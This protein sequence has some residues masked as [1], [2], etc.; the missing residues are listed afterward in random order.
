M[1]RIAGWLLVSLACVAFALPAI[2]EEPTGTLHISARPRCTVEIDGKDY[3]TTDDTRKGIPLPAGSYTVR[4]VCA[5]EEKCAQFDKRSGRKTLA[6]EA[7]KETRYL[8]D[9][10][11]L[12]QRGGRSTSSSSPEPAAAPPP[13][14][15]GPAGALTLT[16]K[17][18]ARVEIGSTAYGSIGA[19]PWTVWLPPGEHVVRFVCEG[20]ACD[21]MTRRS[22][23]KTIAITEDA[24]TRYEV[25]FFGLNG[26]GAAE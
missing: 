11:A 7:G 21:G 6:V 16:A 10:Y 26:T 2:A 8:A 1:V 13:K 25:D 4:F 15:E 22:G 19:E 24:E 20:A 23:R 12:N 5:D 3:G 18:G 14:P 17:P 9:F